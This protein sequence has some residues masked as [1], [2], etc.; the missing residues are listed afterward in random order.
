MAITTPAA[1]PIEAQ[2]SF[3]EDADR[4]RHHTPPYSADIL[5]PGGDRAGDLGNQYVLQVVGR[6]IY[7][8]P[9]KFFHTHH[10]LRAYS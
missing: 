10:T 5:L 6:G 7:V 8:L 3:A 1:R 2:A 4:D 9:I